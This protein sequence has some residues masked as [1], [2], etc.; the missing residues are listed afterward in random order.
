MYI[1]LTSC[2][3]KCILYTLLH[4]YARIGSGQI[5]DQT[6]DEATTE[7]RR[8]MV[9]L[10]EHRESSAVPDVT[11]HITHTVMEWKNQQ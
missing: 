7:R 9:Q 11:E 8:H 10:K 1:S 4:K 3:N 2:Q 5:L 6:N